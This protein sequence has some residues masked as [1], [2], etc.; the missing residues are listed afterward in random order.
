MRAIEPPPA[1]MVRMSIIGIW[2]GRPHSISKSVVNFSLPLTTV[3]TSVEVP[4]MSS[5]TRLGRPSS[6]A[7]RLAAITPPVG[8]ET[9]IWIGAST[10]ASRLISPP[11]E[12]MT[13]IWALTPWSSSSRRIEPSCFSTTGLMKASQIV[14]EERKCSFHFGKTS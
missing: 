1:P 5:V 11:L 10:A 7:V 12:R 3:E 13:T 8:P 14:V 9:A 4:P 2:I 6:S